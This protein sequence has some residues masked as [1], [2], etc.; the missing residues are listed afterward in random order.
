MLLKIY[1]CQARF[2]CASGS[3]GRAWAA[4][5]RVGSSNQEAVHACPWKAMHAPLRSN[6]HVDACMPESRIVP[7][8]KVHID[9]HIFEQ[10]C[11]NCDASF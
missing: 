7:C 10:A 3:I 11:T 8:I 4:E 5:Q 9:L 1:V 6:F 2:T